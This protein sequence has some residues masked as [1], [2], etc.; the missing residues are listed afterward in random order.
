MDLGQ[1][2]RDGALQE[3]ASVAGV[4]M[5]HHT[6]LGFL[7]RVGA[8]GGAV[9]G[10]G[11]VLGALAPDALAAT[12][13]MGRRYQRGR[14]PVSFGKGDVG[15][16]N[17]AL[18]LEY[19]ESTFYNEAKKAGAITDPATMAFLNLTVTDEN[20][21][22]RILES[23]LGADAIKRPVFDF[24]GIP[25][26]EKKFQETAF[27]LEN[28]GVHAYIGQARNLYSPTILTYAAGIATIEG[29]H[30]AIIGSILDD[31]VGHTAPNGPVD[32]PLSAN[33]VLLAVKGTGFIVSGAPAGTGGPYTPPP[34]P[35]G[36]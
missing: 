20:A 28:T 15:I 22:V 16:A 3:A 19:L 14:P 27:V 23:L 4:E 25:E 10:G 33:E 5:S 21:H 6:R 12:G 32:N 36:K 7:R 24:Q 11:A 17:F 1:F 35:E 2:D 9:A 8:V 18:L 31:K 34:S 13:G 29:R 26:D 30:A